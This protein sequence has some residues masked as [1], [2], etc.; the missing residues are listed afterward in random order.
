MTVEASWNGATVV[1]SWR[2]LSGPSPATLAAVAGASK[3]GFETTIRVPA[4]AAYVQ[5]QALNASGEVI[6]TSTAMQPSRG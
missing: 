2:L 1:A 4:P 3:T 6:G 5:M